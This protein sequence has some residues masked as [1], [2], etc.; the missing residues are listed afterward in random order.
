MRVL[1]ARGSELEHE[2]SYGVVRQLFEPLLAS[3]PR[4]ERDDL[5]AD[6]AGLASP[7]FDPTQLGAEPDEDSSL[8][9]LHGLFWLTAN[10]TDRRPAPRDRRPALVRSSSLRWLAYLLARLEGLS[11]LIVVGLRPAEPGADVACWGGSR[12]IHSRPC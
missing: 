8:A 3:A 6:A 12:P 7:I 1:A 10:L 5:L 4:E 11:L 2:F 9:M